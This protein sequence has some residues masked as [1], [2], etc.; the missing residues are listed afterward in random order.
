[1]Y[2]KHELKAF[3]GR[4]SKDPEIRFLESGKAVTT[5]SIPLGG[6]RENPEETFW[7]NCEYWNGDDIA[8]KIKKGNYITVFGK[9]KTEEY[10]GK[11]RLKFVVA[12]WIK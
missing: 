5:F 2:A 8:E 9:F 10:Q 11:E 4:L 3:H 12:N 7:L 6:S 1:M